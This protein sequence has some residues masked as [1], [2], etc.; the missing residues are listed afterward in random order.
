MHIWARPWPAVAADHAAPT[1]TCPP[2]VSEREVDLVRDRVA[3]LNPDTP[4]LRT[5]GRDGVSPALLLGLDTRLFAAAPAGDAAAGLGAHYD[6]E[7]DTLS[8]VVRDD[9][10]FPPAPPVA[11]TLA[12]LAALPAEHVFRVKGT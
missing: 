2:Q 3:D 4:V 6:S 8:V 1:C 11:D 9:G 7:L 5:Q 10:S 12:R